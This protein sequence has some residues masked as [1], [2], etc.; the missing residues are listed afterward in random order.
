MPC[1]ELGQDANPS[2][3]LRN[4][5]ALSGSLGKSSLLPRLADELTK[6]GSSIFF[7]PFLE[8]VYFPTYREVDQ[9]LK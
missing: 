7:K 5:N 9:L 1:V 4:K 2:K 3:R 6:T 8:R